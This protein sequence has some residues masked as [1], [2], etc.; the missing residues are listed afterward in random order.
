[1]NT[2]SSDGMLKGGEAGR[3]VAASAVFDAK[4]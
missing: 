4:C 1:M 3:V 2:P